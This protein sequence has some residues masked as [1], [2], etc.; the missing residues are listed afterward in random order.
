MRSRLMGK[1]VLAVQ[2]EATFT[3]GE[4]HARIV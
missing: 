4:R 2:I 1:V 3:V